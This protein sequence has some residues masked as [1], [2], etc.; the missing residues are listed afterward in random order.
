MEMRKTFK[1]LFVTAALLAAGV[2]GCGGTPV[3][4]A[5]EEVKSSLSRDMAP[6]SENL[7][8]LTGGNRDFGFD[9]FHELTAAN[10]GKNVFISGHSV[11]LALAMAYAGAKGNTADQMAAVLGFA[12]DQAATHEAF[13]ALDLELDKRGSEELA[14]D[15]DGDPFEL[16]V[17]NQAWGRVGFEFL[18]T[19]LDVLALNYGAGLRLLDFT[20]DPDGSRVTINDWVEDETHERIVDLLPEGSI[21]PATALVLTNVIY[22]KASWLKKFDKSETV[23]AQFTKTDGT[24][25]DVKMMKKYDEAR[26]GVGDGYEYLEVPYVGENVAMA[27]ILPDADRFD[28]I[29]AE[30]DGM[31]FG[32]M[33]AGA[34][35]SSGTLRLPR[36]TFGFDSALN[37]SLKALGMT[38]AFSGGIADFSGIDGLPGNLFISLVQHKSFVAVDED[39]TEAAAATAVVMDESSGPVDTYDMTF[40]RPFLFAIIDR[41]TGAV[42][43]LGR[44]LDPTVQ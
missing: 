14:P 17:V 8:A 11:S 18:D 28:E 4:Q 43:F 16:S 40:D 38:D 41:P 7:A 2:Y 25:V 44:V 32:A 1:V 6:S 24:K 29:E 10:A 19:Y 36:F 42:L 21:S 34:V 37:N 15:E 31:S 9:L 39:G 26:H 13:N 33:V 20:N 35:A 12:G 22:F 5:G 3:I 27:L 23:D 30:L